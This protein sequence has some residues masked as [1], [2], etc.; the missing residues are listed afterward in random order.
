MTNLVALG[1]AGELAQHAEAVCSLPDVQLH[2]E[3]ANPLDANVHDGLILLDID[4]KAYWVDAALEAGLPVLATHPIQRP[5]KGRRNE[6]IT[7]LCV[8]SQ[9][10]LLRGHKSIQENLLLDNRISYYELKLTWDST[11]FSSKRSDVQTQMGL[12]ACDLLHLISGPVDE[13]Y[14]HTRN[15]F[16]AGPVEDWAMASL[17][18]RNGCEALL[19]LVDYPGLANSLEI[20]SYAAGGGHMGEVAI[21]L[22][23]QVEDLR[24]YYDNFLGCICKRQQ[25]MVGWREVHESYRLLYW[26]RASARADRVMHARELQW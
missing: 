13:L 16:H 1:T 14:G 25:P 15:F 12:I 2:T 19:Q 11:Q 24:V 8:L 26:L 21:P 9:A 3:S 20:R 18:M 5:D 7:P 4:D 10:R 22:E 17:R 6:S 23:W